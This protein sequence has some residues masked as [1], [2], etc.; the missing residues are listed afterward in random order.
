M[1]MPRSI[2]RQ[3]F[4]GHV[5]LGQ[6]FLSQVFPGQVFLG[7]VFL[8]KV[9]LGKAF[10]GKAFLGKAFLGKAFLRHALLGSVFA[11]VMLSNAS[12]AP[13]ASSPERRGKMFARTHCARCH[14]IDRSSQSPFQAAPPFRTLN[15][16]YP[17]ETLG[18]ALAEGIVTGHPSMP[19]FELTP[20][21]IHDLLAFL[22]TFE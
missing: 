21:Q 20:D 10:L 8:G 2:L 9:F 1:P 19:Q 15:L 18:E 22:K 11:A 5:F 14:A 12:P 7:Q 3:A 4:P 6:V 13:A 17:I 16:R